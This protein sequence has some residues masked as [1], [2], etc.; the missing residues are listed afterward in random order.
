MADGGDG[1]LGLYTS[2]LTLLAGH[3]TVSNPSLLVRVGAQIP[4]LTGT[5]SRV[6]VFD[7]VNQ[8][9]QL[10]CWVSTDG[11]AQAV[12]RA[13]PERTPLLILPGIAGTFAADSTSFTTWLLQRG[14]A[15]G[16]L[17]ADPLAGVYD[18]LIR[19]LENAGYQ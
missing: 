12:V 18:G 8:S 3:D 19:T 9:G 2:R 4:G 15:P 6:S 11:G 5:V 14:I 10:A 7:P 17:Q 1:N 13:K 16:Q